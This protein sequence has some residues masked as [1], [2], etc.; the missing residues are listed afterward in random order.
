VVQP[1][2]SS[3]SN[4]QGVDVNDLNEAKSS[5]KQEYAQFNAGLQVRAKGGG[6]IRDDRK[7]SDCLVKIPFSYCPSLLHKDSGSRNPSIPE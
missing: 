2:E 1:G 7:S 3:T 5:F 6:N 4:I